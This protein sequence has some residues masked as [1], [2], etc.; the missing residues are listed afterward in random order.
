LDR[1]ALVL[2][3]GD[4]RLGQLEFIILGVGAGDVGCGG[5]GKAGERDPQG[6]R[7]SKPAHC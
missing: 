2:A 1:D 6:A 3:D 5:Q 4:R 7:D